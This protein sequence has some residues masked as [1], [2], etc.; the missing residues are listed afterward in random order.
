M[1]LVTVISVCTDTHCH[2]CHF[3]LH[4]FTLSFLPFL[5][6]QIHT[7]ISAC[8]NTHRHNHTPRHTISYTRSHNPTHTIQLT[9]KLQCTQS[10]THIHT[11]TRTCTH[12]CTHS[13]THTHIQTL[14]LPSYSFKKPANTAHTHMHTLQHIHTRS[15]THLAIL[16]TQGISRHSTVRSLQVVC[17]IENVLQETLQDIRMCMFMWGVCMWGVCVCGVC[18]C[19]SCMHACNQSFP[20]ITI[21]GALPNLDEANT[22]GTLC[23]LQLQGT[24]PCSTILDCYA[25]Y[26]MIMEKEYRQKQDLQ[27]AFNAPS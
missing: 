9:L 25:G 2:F 18:V 8:I 1:A 23:P 27:L 22:S 4:R 6:A 21:F 3:C 12:T 26:L 17:H 20:C 10:P 5:F 11:Q 15:N 24:Q 14:T 19:V 13:N 7:V 16:F